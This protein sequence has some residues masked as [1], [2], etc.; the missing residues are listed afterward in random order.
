MSGSISFPCISF[1]TSSSKLQYVSYPTCSKCPDWISPSRLPAPLISKS[2][3]AI[4][5]PDPNSV[6]S[7]IAFNLLS[8]TSASIL[9]FLY[10][11]YAYP[12][13]L[14][15]PTLPLIW[16]SCANPILSAFSTIIVFAFGMSIPDS[17]IVVHTNTFVFFSINSCIMSSISFPVI[18][19]CA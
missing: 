6:N 5:N 13:L 8:A 16:Y 11:M 19:P 10:V 2:L 3:I 17:S 4:L 7:F 14:L 9:S 15:L 12:C 1:T 18:L